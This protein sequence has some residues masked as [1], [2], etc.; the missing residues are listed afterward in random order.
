MLF[1]QKLLQQYIIAALLP[2][3]ILAAL[4]LTVS[5]L[6]QQS[7][8]F[9]E[10]IGTA[11]APLSLSA[12]ILV[13]LLPN[14][15]VFALPMATLIGTATGFSRMGSDS[16]LIAIRAAGVGTTRILIPVLL[17]GIALSLLTLWMSF[18]IA[19]SAAQ[20]LRQ[21]ALRAAL[22]KLESPIEPRSFYTEMPGKVVYVRD[23]DQQSGQWGRV[24]IY[25]QERNEP[26]RLVTARTGRIDSSG[27]QSELV[28]N[29]AVITTLP[30]GEGTGERE[31]STQVM[32][33]RS[34]QLRI[35]DD[36]LDAG[37]RA[38]L[39]RLRE[40]KPELD[41]MNWQELR[42]QTWAAGDDS[43]RRNAAIALQRR[44]ALSFAPLIFAWL[45]AAMG[46]RT[47]RGG[48]GLGVVLSLAAM[49]GYY[50]F[51]LAGEQLVRAGVLPVVAGLWLADVLAVVSGALLLGP[52]VW[53]IRPGRRRRGAQQREERHVQPRAPQTAWSWRKP[54]LTILGL[55][56]RSLLRSLTWSFTV[57]LTV[58]VSIF[59]IFTL[60]ELLR[61]I[62]AGGASTRVVLRYVFFLLP[63]IAV[64]L[65]P[66]SM[67][68]AILLTYALMSR[69]SE[70]VAWWSSGQSVYRL[71]VP[72]LLF[73]ALA[74]VGLWTIQE[75]LMP[76]ANRQQNT[77]RAQIREGISRT[78]VV[79]GRQWLA[80]HEARRLYAF[81]FAEQSQHLLAPSIYEFD[82]EGVHLRRIINGAVGGWA[83]PTTP[84]L[85]IDAV[86]V[87]DL[88]NSERI[89]VTAER[90]FEETAGMELFKPLHNRPSEQ[91]FKQLSASIRSLKLRGGADLAPLVMALERKRVDPFSPLVM[92]CLGIPCAL[93]FGKRSAL[94]ALSA[95]VGI[96]L[97][98][99]AAVSGF[100]QLGVAG[101]LPPPL[102]A[103]A[104]PAI[105]AAVGVYLLSRSRT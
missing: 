9:A 86:R 12:E 39:Q 103:W 23:G 57:T 104:P 66:M 101:L 29:D 72:G 41:E 34:A 87:V 102:A 90:T 98:F 100:Q 83:T 94:S 55:L 43:V 53:L 84:T 61:F 49:L 1:R 80:D 89:T 81:E 70:A 50:L 15:L 25:W 22:Y 76:Q 18:S 59:L 85:R 97:S 30:S 62:T 6:A 75:Q 7:T 52:D 13:E 77:L 27:E 44:W 20:N 45:G 64:S 51:S 5:L 17:T 32:T 93:A 60:F 35:R 56:D 40:R 26:V 14:V 69:R 73:A 37:R 96:G 10:I 74:G 46:L 4:I 88:S 36:R 95:A 65:F 38:L 11:R 47:R 3:L 2:Y 19:P 79:G 8:R 105:F 31:R 92:A 42:A 68:V 82:A 21:T 33:E 58:M 78:E 54:G 91:S 48:R 99:W 24:F 16:E 63:F 28:L 67:L 71:A